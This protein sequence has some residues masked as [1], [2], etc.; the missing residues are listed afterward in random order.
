MALRTDESQEY[1]A[2]QRTFDDME[3]EIETMHSITRFAG[4]A[5]TLLSI[6]QERKDSKPRGEPSDECDLETVIIDNHMNILCLYLKGIKE[7]DDRMSVMV[8]EAGESLLSNE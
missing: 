2:E 8:S 7:F 6:L 4:E 1:M 3:R 5:E